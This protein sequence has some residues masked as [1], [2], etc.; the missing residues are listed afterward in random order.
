[1]LPSSPVPPPTVLPVL[2]PLT[3]LRSM[4][5]ARRSL[6]LI[7]TLRAALPFLLQKHP[8]RLSK[9]LVSTA[10]S[11]AS[12]SATKSVRVETRFAAAGVVAPAT[13]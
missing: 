2:R 7:W 4:L 6:A 8:P 1:M 13:A 3:H 5:P 9:T 11:V 10:A 12:L